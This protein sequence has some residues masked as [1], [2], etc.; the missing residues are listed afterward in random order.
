MWIIADV[1]EGEGQS[2]LSCKKWITK[3]YLLQN[4]IVGSNKVSIQSRWFYC[5]S[6]CLINDSFIEGLETEAVKQTKSLWIIIGIWLLQYNAVLCFY[7]VQSALLFNNSAIVLWTQ[8]V[9][10]LKSVSILTY[11][12]VIGTRNKGFIVNLYCEL[13]VTYGDIHRNELVMYKN[14]VQVIHYCFHKR[15]TE[16][17]IQHIYLYLSEIQVFFSLNTLIR[18]K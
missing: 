6:L 13:L 17:H 18:S 9:R 16:N 15:I 7:C 10:S 14:I 12:H 1:K 11:G 8:T 3:L 2:T 4:S 5:Y